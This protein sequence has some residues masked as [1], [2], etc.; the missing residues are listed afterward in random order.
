MADEY[1][2]ITPSPRIL[3][4]LGEIPFAPW[5]CL[6]ELID[7]S[8]DAFQRADAT[9]KERR[10]VVSWSGD[11]TA[12]ADQ[13]L[14]VLDT[15]PGMEIDSLQNS[16]RAGYS[17]K[18][19]IS[20][21]GL[22]GMGFNIATARLGEKT[23]ILSAT[24]TSKEWLG[25]EIDFGE[26]SKKGEFNAP[27]RRLPKRSPSEHGTRVIVS[28]LKPGIVSTLRASGAQIRRILEDIYTPLLQKT[29]VEIMVQS[30]ILSPA[31]HCVWD[32]KRYVANRDETVAA[33]IKLDEPIGEA[34]FDLEKNRYLTPD[35][36]ADVRR[37]TAN[38]LP[39]TVA[40]R[41]K[42]VTGWIGI[43]RYPDPDDFGIDFIRNGRKILIGDKSLFSFQNPLTGRSEI[44]YP[45]ELGNTVGGRIVGEIHVDHIP[46]TYQKNDFDRSDP[47]WLETVEYLRG[48]GPVLPA[49]RRAMGFETP[50]ASPLA[51]LITAYRRTDIGTRCLAAPHRQAREW[52]DKFRKGDPEFATDE[53]WWKAAQE[54]DRQKADKG[55]ADAPAVDPGNASSD[56]P[57]SYGPAASGGAT[58]IVKPAVPT[59]PA[60]QTLNTA[61]ELKARARK[62]ETFSGDYA[63]EGCRSPFSVTVWE[64]TGGRIG[65][66]D[67]GTPCMLFSEGNTC[68]FFYNPRHPFL[69]SFPFAFNELLLIYLAEKF[70]A[71]DNKNDLVGL[72][73]S[74]TQEKL[75][76]RRIEHGR[77]QE[78]AKS[79]FDRFRESAIQLLSVREQ[80]VIDCIHLSAGEVEETVAKLTSRPD[81]LQKFQARTVG[82]I[83]AL[84]VVPSRTLIR[85]VERFP[86]ELLDGKF[87]RMPYTAISLP[88]QN[89]TD[90]LR[91][92]AKER[93]LS[94][95]KDALWILSDSDSST[96]PQ[97]RKNELARCAHSLNF[98]AQ[99]TEV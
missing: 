54:A 14:E 3:R 36:E 26:L 63:Y 98:L 56:D 15:G 78:V 95:L 97:R 75:S 65:P 67:T 81:L 31:P 79:F 43:Q 51:R 38:K 57:G 13:V 53:K 29:S 70:K 59:A 86:E 12:Q 62:I 50:N 32:E 71:R 76:D 89:A 87:F 52:A 34:L 91:N 21:L 85:L 28:K 90:R 72:F 74:L 83:D 4:T 9:A 45:V 19:P 25:I 37:A 30:K 24:P 5:Q 73:V 92:G 60:K 42:R 41:K 1:I 94:Y 27:L 40:V 84:S 64:L 46:P 39:T 93:L 16:A 96:S 44:E 7:N 6:A 10:I 66:G 20:T 23:L 77:I 47:S 18:N 68:D 17:G 48:P 22:F 82:A 55:A 35:E 58:V 88:D 2:D 80:E 33:I 49:K 69:T 11:T 8:L 99:E 61:D